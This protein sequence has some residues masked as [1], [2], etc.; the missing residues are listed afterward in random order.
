MNDSM[1]KLTSS[2][3]VHMD[4]DLELA[5]RRLADADE[6][7]L[8]TYCR[9]ILKRHVAMVQATDLAEQVDTPCKL[10][11][12]GNARGSPFDDDGRE[13]MA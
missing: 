4:D 5:L 7:D 9:V 12:L 1:G 11:P 13:R 8:S 6:R 3:R 2:V 10:V